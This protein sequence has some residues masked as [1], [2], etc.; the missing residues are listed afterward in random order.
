MSEAVEFAG[1]F[2]FFWLFLFSKRYRVA[3]V[4]EW[5]DGE[6][7]ER[8][9]LLLEAAVSVLVGVVIPVALLWALMRT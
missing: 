9:F 2:L 6:W 4:A 7:L 8:A 5:R 3:R 1:Y